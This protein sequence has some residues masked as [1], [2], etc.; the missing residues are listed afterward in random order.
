MGRNNLYKFLFENK[1]L[2]LNKKP[3]QKYSNYFKCSVSHYQDSQ[4]EIRDNVKTIVNQKGIDFILKTYNRDK[5]N[6]AV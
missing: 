5:N 1:I 4:G 2:M 6:K 3:Y